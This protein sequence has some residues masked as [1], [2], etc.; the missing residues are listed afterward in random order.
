MTSGAGMLGGTAGR[1]V[2]TLGLG[3]AQG[4][5]SGPVAAG[6]GA[7]ASSVCREMPLAGCSG[8]PELAADGG[9]LSCHLL[10]L[11]TTLK[12]F[13]ESILWDS[14][15]HSLWHGLCSSC[16]SFIPP[17]TPQ[18]RV[19]PGRSWHT[20]KSKMIQKAA[21]VQSGGATVMS[22]SQPHSL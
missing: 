6:A 3:G 19:Q 20:E 12:Y 13:S 18:R 9:V 2:L 5:R 22:V 11:L 14:C 1:R 21:W 16:T 8:S 7:G 17:A 15:C 10:H 4:S